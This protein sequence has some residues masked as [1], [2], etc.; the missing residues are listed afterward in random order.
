VLQRA[1][2]FCSEG[3]AS[4]LFAFAGFFSAVL[5]C[6]MVMADSGHWRSSR[7]SSIRRGEQLKEFP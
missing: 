2:A 3:K 7:L 1:S 5:D 6:E 4:S